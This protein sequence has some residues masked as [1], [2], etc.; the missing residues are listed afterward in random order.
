MPTTMVLTT[1]GLA[2]EAAAKVNNTTPSL[3]SIQIGRGQYTP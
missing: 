1:A 3:D 2:L